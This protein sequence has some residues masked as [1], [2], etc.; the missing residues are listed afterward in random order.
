[1]EPPKAWR[2]SPSSLIRTVTTASSELTRKFWTSPSPQRPFRICDHDRTTRTGVT[3]GSLRELINKA[4]DVLL[5]TGVVTLVLEEDGTA[6]D[7]EDFFQHLDDDTSFM[8]LQ[9]GQ[10]WKPPKRGMVSCSLIQKP[11]NARDIAR[12]TFDIYKLNPRDLFGSLNVRATFYGLYSM[13]FDVKCLG[14]K[15]VLSREYAGSNYV[16]IG[17]NQISDESN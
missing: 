11:R 17:K 4:L 10:R 15:K 2:C 9:K 12:I 5:L 7:N 8:V 16:G 6:V 1:M 3:A 14:P 13:T